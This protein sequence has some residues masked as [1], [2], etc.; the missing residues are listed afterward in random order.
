MGPFAFISAQWDDIGSMR[1]YA[2]YR[3]YTFRALIRQ[4]RHIAMM[5]V[6]LALC[7]KALVPTGYMLGSSGARF[8]TVQI[9]SDGL[10]LHKVTQIAI[11][12]QGNSQDGHGEHGKADSP[13]AYSALSMA[14]LGGADAPLLAIALAFILVLGF[15]AIAPTPLEQ[16]SHLRP[17]LRGPPAVA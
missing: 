17:P 14:S 15:V 12:I 10:Q 7:M 3:V 13:C 16:I 11:P 5:I 9:C 1:A 6:A 2:R 8:L 4:H